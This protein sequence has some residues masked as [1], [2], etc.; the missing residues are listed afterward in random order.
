MRKL[1]PQEAALLDVLQRER[2]IL[3]SADD[4]EPVPHSLMAD[5]FNSLVK[6]KRAVAEQTDGGVRYHAA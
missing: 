6:K 1:T 5:L 4:L 3:L 2:S